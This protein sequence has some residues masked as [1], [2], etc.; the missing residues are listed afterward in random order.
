MKDKKFLV[1]CILGLVWL[2]MFIAMLF[3]A[4]IH[5][6]VEIMV[7]V[8]CV[9]WFAYWTVSA[10]KDY[11]RKPTNTNENGNTTQNNNSAE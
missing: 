4:K 2:V 7:Y 3:G 10:V 9:L 1:L 8:V 11:F 5:P 6:R